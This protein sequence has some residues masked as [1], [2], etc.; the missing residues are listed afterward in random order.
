MMQHTS[1]VITTVIFVTAMIVIRV[2]LIVIMIITSVAAEPERTLPRVLASGGSFPSPCLALEHLRVLLALG[3]LNRWWSAKAR[4]PCAMHYGIQP[5]GVPWDAASGGVGCV[6][7]SSESGASRFQAGS[8]QLSN[9]IFKREVFTHALRP[10]CKQPLHC[11]LQ[12]LP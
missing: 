7:T 6:S 11:Y 3:R 9:V 4:Q 2:L 8:E 5:P 12:C 1:I 10:A